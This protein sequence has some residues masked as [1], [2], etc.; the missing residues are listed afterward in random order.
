M[1]ELHEES[2]HHPSSRVSPNLCETHSL[3]KMSGFAPVSVKDVGEDNDH[4]D[5]REEHKQNRKDYDVNVQLNEMMATL[6]P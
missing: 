4:H 1:R 2:T 3:S 5:G 6:V